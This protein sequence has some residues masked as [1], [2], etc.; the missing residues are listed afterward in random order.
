MAA[1][2]TMHSECVRAVF[3]LHFVGGGWLLQA[4]EHAWVTSSNLHSVLHWS[5]VTPEGGADISYLVQYTIADEV[6][7]EMVEWRNVSSCSSVRTTEC[8][9]SFEARPYIHVTFR[10]RAQME[11]QT[12]PW[13]QTKPFNARLE[14]ELNPPNFTLSAENPNSL[15][16]VMEPDTRLRKAFGVLLKYRVQIKKENGMLTHLSNESSSAIFQS[17]QGGVKYC[18]QVQYV[19][20]HR[21]GKISEKQCAVVKEAESDKIIRIVWMSSLLVIVFGALVV[22]I[23]F[24]VYRNYNKLK[25]ALR[26]AMQWPEYLEELLFRDT[27][28]QVAQLP[29]S[30]VTCEETSH[31][32]LILTDAESVQSVG[33]SSAQS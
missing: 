13:S 21:L 17:L 28:T 9:I 26:P 12:S 1:L 3:F 2:Q 6:G 33:A 4:P 7:D 18:V 31:I 32:S 27:F 22:G 25:G 11:N 16:V 29:S 19:L 15:V 24:L 30:N 8:N 5:P 20:E 23:I 10:V 14:T